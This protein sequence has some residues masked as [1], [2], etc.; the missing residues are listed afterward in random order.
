MQRLTL[1]LVLAGLVAVGAL[2]FTSGPQP[3]LEGAITEVRTL[4]VEPEAAVALVNFRAANITPNNF[5]AYERRLEIID[6]KGETYRGTTVNTIDLK[7]LFQYFPELGGMKDEPFGAKTEIPSGETVRGLIAARFEVSKEALDS[8]QA[9]LIR[10][11]DGVGRETVLRDP[12][13]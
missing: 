4:T 9:L 6:A 13:E 5:V 3:R 12:P 7:D 8:R 2:F 11:T 10:V 1:V